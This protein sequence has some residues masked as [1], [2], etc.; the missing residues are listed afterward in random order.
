MFTRSSRAGLCSTLILALLACASM[1]ERDPADV[2][3]I[4]LRGLA[5][6]AQTSELRV[7]T[8]GDQPPLSMVTRDGELVGLDVALARVL[9]QTMGVKLVLVQRPFATL[10]DTLDANEVDLVISGMTITPARARRATFVGPY[11]TSGKCILTKSAKLAETPP[12]QL[13]DISNVRLAALAGSTSEEFVRASIP[14]ATLVLSDQLDQA[15][16]QVLQGSVDGLVAD[17]ESC[18][19]ALLRYPDAGLIESENTYTIEPMGIALAPEDVR[20]TRMVETY[21]NALS[22]RGVLERSKAFWFENPEW[23]KGVR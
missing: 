20:L 23:V 22:E 3:A 7:G 16:D 17:R 4:P 19:Y 11:Y 2:P 12:E 13:R 10:L 1:R 14:N 21:L 18:S 9:A 6:V 8:S 5:R 15:I